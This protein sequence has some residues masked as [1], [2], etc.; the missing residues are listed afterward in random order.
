MPLTNW[1]NYTGWVRWNWLVMTVNSL[2]LHAVDVT[3][4]NSYSQCGGSINC[5]FQTYT[6]GAQPLTPVTLILKEW[7]SLLTT[8]W[9]WMV[10]ISTEMHFSSS[11]ALL[12]QN[13]WHMQL[14]S[15]KCD[16]CKQWQLNNKTSVLFYLTV[17]GILNMDTKRKRHTLEWI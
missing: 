6:N 8:D 15:F 2:I 5:I 12:F 3:A 10:I 1:F 4:N 9:T 16:G 17:T 7:F 13:K 14:H 11:T